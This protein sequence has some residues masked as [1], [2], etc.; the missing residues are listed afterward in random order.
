[1]P[2]DINAARRC[3][4]DLQSDEEV[5]AELKEICAD[6]QEHTIANESTRFKFLIDRFDHLGG[7]L[8]IGDFMVGYALFIINIQFIYTCF[9]YLFSL[10]ASLDK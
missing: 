10:I 6:T 1:M 8:S 2:V 5:I 4:Y 7:I 3:F 9:V